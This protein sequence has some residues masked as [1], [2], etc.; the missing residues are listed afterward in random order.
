MYIGPDALIPIPKHWILSNL[1]IAIDTYITN[2]DEQPTLGVW[3]VVDMFP[4]N[5]G[6][7]R[8]LPLLFVEYPTAAN[9]ET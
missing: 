8:R 7:G 4:E 1:T 2:G 5:G 6:K 3:F 9:D